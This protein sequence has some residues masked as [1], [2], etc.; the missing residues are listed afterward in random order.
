MKYF[1]MKELTRSETAVEHNIDNTPTDE[2]ERWLE[3]LVD[4]ILDPLR[5]AYGDP[6]RVNSGYRCEELN[7]A[8]GG[9][10]RSEHKFGMAAD[11][12]AIET[13]RKKRKEKNK[14]IFEMCISLG[15]P[16]HQLIDESG[17]SWIHVSFNPSAKVQRIVKHL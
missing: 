8:V 14:R 10:D 17:F 5:E 6:I 4:N 15:L 1:T 9:S 11:I 2:A 16:Y 7:A 13:N 3:R 12:T